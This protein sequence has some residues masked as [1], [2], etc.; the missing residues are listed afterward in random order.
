[1][2]Q[3]DFNIANQDFPSTRADLNNALLALA[4]NSGGASAPGT[5]VPNQWWVD[6][7]NN[8]LRIRNR[9]NTAWITV[10]SVDPTGN[11]FE[12][13][14]RAIQALDDNGL[15]LQTNDN[16][17][18]VFLDDTGGLGV[19]AIA[20]STAILDLTSTTKGFRP[21]R[22]TTTQKNAISS[23]P[24][25]LIVYDT[26]LNALSI[27]NGT[28]WASL[29]TG[30]ASSLTLANFDA[31]VVVT[32]AEGLNANDNDSTFPT[33]AAVK[34]YVDANDSA[35]EWSWHPYN[36]V[37]LGDSNTGLIWSFAANGAQG[38][39][40]TPDFVAGYDYRISVK[41]LTSTS[42]GS[43]FVTVSY[44]RQVANILSPA[45]QLAGLP[46]TTSLY[47]MSIEMYNPMKTAQQ[48]RGLFEIASH[49][50]SSGNAGQPNIA[51]VSP[52]GP[53]FAVAD[54][55]LRMQISVSGG[56]NTYNGG[57][58]YLER[59]RTVAN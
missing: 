12:P 7:T 33:S 32:E 4:T 35:W 34:G 43:H 17:D 30:G 5:T 46:A 28:G 39:I 29:A 48:F 51:S 40:N 58:M 45:H 44:F 53:Y 27:F 2:A 26:T 31:A 49:V 23:P 9:T 55:V 15:I 16:A 38:T 57:A 21:P 11:L 10:G 18:R 42:I 13:R 54:R 47:D 59:R 56:G 41:S 20:A 50:P 37:T 14:V 36:K 3:H 8:L 52:I 25:G 6:E 24:A 1:M 22:L 19:G